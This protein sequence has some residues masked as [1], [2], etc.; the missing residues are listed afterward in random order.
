MGQF[1]QFHFLIKRLL[2]SSR[3]PFD[4]ELKIEFFELINITVTGIFLELLAKNEWKTGH[5]NF[6]DSTTAEMDL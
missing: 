3:T 1:R 2:P 5:R 4:A 6:A